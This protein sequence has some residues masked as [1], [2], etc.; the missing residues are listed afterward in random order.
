[1]L[2][3]REHWSNRM[4]FIMAAV[5]S[6]VGLG[7]LWRF[8]AVCAENGGGAFLLPYF[9]ALATVG[10]PLLILEFSLGH[11]MQ[12]AVPL[13]V[14]KIR[15]SFKWVG[16]WAVLGGFIIVCFYA[17]VMAW[18]LE[19]LVQS[20]NSEAINAWKSNKAGDFFSKNI[21]RTTKGLGASPGGMVWPIVGY[22]AAC[23][24]IIYLLIHK[25]V[26]QVGKVVLITVPL[27][28]ILVLVLFFRGITLDGAM[29]G[30]TKYLTPN[31][32]ML[33]KPEV[34]RA[35]YGQIFFSLS[36]GF[37]VM[38]A[39]ASY[40]DRKADI[41]NNALMTGL[42][43]CGFS[44]FAGFAVFSVLG[45]LAT[46]TNDMAV[47]EQ[48]GGSLAFIAY[49]TA[50]AQLP[51]TGFFAA[52]FFI[53][54]LS[55]GIDS[56]FSIVEGIT[57]AVMEKFNLGR[58]VA[59]LIVCLLGFGGG[60]IFCTQNGDAYLTA[61][62]KF[63]DY[64]MIGAALALCIVVGWFYGA[65]KMRRYINLVSDIKIGLW[66]DVVIIVIAPL[67]LTAVL[68][69]NIIEAVRH[70]YPP[71]EAYKGTIE[72][73]C[74]WIPL[75]AS[76]VLATILMAVKSKHGWATTASMIKVLTWLAIAVAGV[77]FY[78]RY[79]E[80]VMGGFGCIFLYGGLGY[81]I[82]RAR[83]AKRE[84]SMPQPPEAVNHGP[85]EHPHR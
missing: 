61:T 73:Y 58:H 52:L 65:R 22:L 81:C 10:I 43:N 59:L 72:L 60:L 35:A 36:I 55:L 51:W 66:W 31:W 69:W 7:N 64:G 57:A 46:Q 13:A 32:E 3:P 11:R 83:K 20:F 77:V 45:F 2:E 53:T 29:V 1:M 23:W 70:E 56:A 24:A 85:G 8:P 16:W 49:P 15:P 25:G 67:L 63:I 26:K 4:S 82:H 38:V 17:V 19:Y 44:F 54:L 41:T 14:E 84:A 18:C 6:A 37:G 9:I 28:I 80:W 48:G 78:P 42:I 68:V 40:L 50:L 79:P 21:L 34:W 74:G 30:L 33:G 27:P 71:E 76:I 5:G 39:Y 12:H 75:L 62:N 47:L